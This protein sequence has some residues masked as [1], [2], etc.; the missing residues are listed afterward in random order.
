VNYRPQITIISGGQT[1]VDRSAL[2]FALLHNLPHHGWCPK[3]RRAED[4]VIAERYHLQETSSRNYPDRT[5]RNIIDSDGTLIIAPRLPLEGGTALTLRLTQQEFK[6]V[7][8]RVDSLELSTAQHQLRSWI[9]A[10]QIARLNVAGPR[11]A[12]GYN[13]TPRVFALLNVLL[14]PTPSF[15]RT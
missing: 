4:G 15:Y 7:L 10:E 6:P 3:G 1:G 11:T 8:T 2:D 14:K 12:P 5:R 13:P 9:D